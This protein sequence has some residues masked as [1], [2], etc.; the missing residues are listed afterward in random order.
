MGVAERHRR[1]VIV[2]E[3]CP[4]RLLT[5]ASGTPCMISHDAKV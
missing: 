1:S 2:G 3:A 4:R 5:V